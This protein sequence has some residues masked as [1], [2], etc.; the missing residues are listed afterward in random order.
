MGN[1][2][3]P[4]IARLSVPSCSEYCPP[5][6]Q[7]SQHLPQ[8][9]SMEDRGFRFC[10]THQPRGGSHNIKLQSR[11]SPL[12]ASLNPIT[13]HVQ[14]QKRLLL[15]RCHDLLPHPQ[16]FSPYRQRCSSTPAPSTTKCSRFLT[17]DPP[18]SSHCGCSQGTSRLRYQE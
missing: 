5:R 2:H 11:Q 6:P 4:T 13:Q 7:T 8:R 16:T 15:P 18:T 17:Y 1:D 9:Q 10:Q 3:I 14:H 12:H